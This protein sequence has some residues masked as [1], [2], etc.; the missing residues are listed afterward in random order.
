[1]SETIRG[2]TVVAMTGVIALCGAI[3]AYGVHMPL[4]WMLG[5]LIAT[6]AASLLGVRI[7]GHPPAMPRQS[8]LVFVPVL[9]I[10]IA[11][12]MTPDIVGGLWRW[13]PSL[14]AVVP[15]V[16]LLQLLNYG[17]F[18]LAGRY[19]PSTAFFAASPGGLV[20]ATL[21]GTR[22][23]GSPARIIMQHSTRVTFS[24]VTIPFLLTAMGHPFVRR[25]LAGPDLAAFTPAMLLEAGAL[26]VA[27]VLGVVIARRLRLPA[28]MM[29]GPFLLGG[30]LY[31]TST[32][33]MT[34]P[35]P[36]IDLAQLVVGASLGVRFGPDDRA[37]ILAALP[38]SV[39][40]LVVSS[41]AAAAAA[42]ALSAVGVASLP[43]LFLSFAPGGLSEMSLIAIALGTDPVFVAAHHMV[44]IIASVAVSPLVYDHLL[45][46]GR[47]TSG[48]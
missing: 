18:R 48:S 35:V 44:R 19:D 24:M 30:V 15:Y 26:V 33:T 41:A 20:E 28:A 10:M 2:L 14:V 1:M 17:V 25:P 4:P 34:V 12:R 46:R 42:A 9:G 23:G 47:A 31:G 7:A 3:L 45:A 6:A 13:W 39:L 27:A 22:H 40:A 21:L 16:V 8:R 11:S 5:P 38:L 32:V 36:L 43:L 29:I 37:A